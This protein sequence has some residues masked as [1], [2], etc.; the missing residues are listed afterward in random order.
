MYIGSHVSI[1][2]GGYAAA[3]KT[4]YGIGGTAFQYFPKNP[5]SLVTKPLWNH[6]DTEACARFSKENGLLSIAHAPYPLN[7]AA[8]QPQQRIML[9]ALI[10]ALE[11]T[12]ACGSVGLVVHFGKYRGKDSLQGYKNIIQL[13]NEALRHWKGKSLL[14]L[15]NQAG[16]G[17]VMGTTMEELVQVR[18]LC[19]T[20]DKIGFC[21]D[22]CHAFASG[23]W[24]GADWQRFEETGVKLGYFQ[25]LKAVHLNDSLYPSGSRR[26]RHANIGQGQIGTDAIKQLLASYYL[27]E[28]PV[29]LETGAARDGTHRIEIA[30]VR[31]LAENP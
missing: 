19:E 29:V 31:K 23:I 21:L 3:A 30:L 13:I 1:S 25:Q 4:A 27:K 7:L 10:N 11:I 17:S 8:D 14:L 16:E 12:E 15:E 2:K 5:R 18:S 28:I 22:T 6:Q 20:P 26:D 24:K 9:D